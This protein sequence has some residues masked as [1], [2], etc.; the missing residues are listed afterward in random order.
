MVKADPFIC[1]DANDDGRVNVADINY[2]INYVFWNGPPPYQY[3]TGDV[4]G[5]WDIDVGDIV[6][7]YNT[8]FKFGPPLSC[9]LK[10]QPEGNQGGGE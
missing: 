1:G 8:M 6:Y 3:Y 2:L 7:L 10:Q 4:D 5:D 9:Q